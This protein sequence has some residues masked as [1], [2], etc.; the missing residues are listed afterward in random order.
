VLAAR[1]RPPLEDAAAECEE[2]GAASVL[3]VPTDVGSDDQV[4][5]LVEAVLDEHD[6]IDSVVNSAGVVAY[7]RV[8]DVPAEVFDGVLR[9]N[10]VGS[11]NVARHVVPVLR[12]QE[13]GNLLL[14]GSVIGH[15]AIPTMSAY[16]LSKWGVRALARQLAIENRD[17]PEVRILYAAPGGVDTPIYAQAANYAGFVGRPPPPAASSDRVAAQLT[18]RLDGGWWPLP[19]QL[20]VLNHA[21]V[22]GYEWL[23]RVYDTL[24]GTVFPLGATDLTKPVAPGPGNVL[25]SRPDG[26]RTDG[27]H[28]S[29]VLGLAQN[30][31]VRLRRRE[32]PSDVGHDLQQA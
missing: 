17:L 10:L 32:P 12:R 29:S 25:A 24:V 6:R 28:G 2:A 19:E 13:A 16:V 27:D 18:R 5:E 20:S 26:N 23:P 15:V 7:G 14:V 9:T 31:L 22:F 8:E 4:R 30:V 11:A 3:V 1:S 21:L